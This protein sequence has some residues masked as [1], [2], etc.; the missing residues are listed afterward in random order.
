MRIHVVLFTAVVSACQATA[1]PFVN[2]DF[3][4]NRPYWRAIGYRGAG[5]TTLGPIEQVMPS[6][7]LEYKGGVYTTLFINGCMCDVNQAALYDFTYASGLPRPEGYFAL[8]L[9]PGGPDTPYV[10]RQRGDVPEDA[11][12]LWFLSYGYP[13]EVRVDGAL[14]AVYS[15]GPRARA[16]VSAW[17]GRT[18]DLSFTAPFAPPWEPPSRWYS[19][20]DSIRFSS[21]VVPEPSALVLLGA[22]AGLVWLALGRRRHGG[23]ASG[24]SSS[25]GL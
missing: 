9:A 20:L 5:S 3:E 21:Q 1:A 16:D 17:A 2:L 11:R 14:L 7:R 25:G 10:L 24:R 13:I 8:W 15:D 6:W 23:A 18:V 19:T 22:G 4:A 12:S